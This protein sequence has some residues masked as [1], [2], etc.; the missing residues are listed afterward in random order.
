M[1]LWLV[2]RWGDDAQMWFVRARARDEALALVFGAET[3]DDDPVDVVEMSHEGEPAVLWESDAWKDQTVEPTSR[4]EP[5]PSCDPCAR[6]GQ[7]RAAHALATE[8]ACWSF[9]E[10]A[11][12]RR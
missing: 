12:R 10:P 2:R 4:F 3:P 8:G 5:G 11:P 9:Q 1:M 7:M 6:C